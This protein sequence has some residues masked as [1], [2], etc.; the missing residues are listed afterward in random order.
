MPIAH[1]FAGVGLHPNLTGL[2]GGGALQALVDGVAG[3][4]LLGSLLAL[5]LGS[6]AWAL[7]SHSHNVHQSMAGRRAVLVSGAAALLI[8]AAPALINFFFDAGLR[9]R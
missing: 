5:V 3:W 7:G 8:G 1:R 2:P 6:V 4:A 9:V